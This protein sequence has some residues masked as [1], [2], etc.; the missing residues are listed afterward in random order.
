MSTGDWVF[1]HAGGCVVEFPPLQLPAT[2]AGAV[3]RASVATL[4]RDPTVPD[5][6]AVLEWTPGERGWTIPAHLAVGDVVEF[7]LAAVDTQDGRVL[8][9]W[10]RRWYSW[11]RYCNELA[12]VVD[13]AHPDPRAAETAANPTMAELRLRQLP[14]LLS[15]DDA[16]FAAPVDDAGR[17]Q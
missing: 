10:E 5:G 12:L 8:A 2:P 11:L 16:T 7:R 1:R 6:W 9:G 13:G 14:S 17:N 4:W 15:G 3:L